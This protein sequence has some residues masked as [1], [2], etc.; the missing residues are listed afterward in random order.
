VWCV[1]QAFVLLSPES[2]KS[3]IVEMIFADNLSFLAM[4]RHA[5]FVVQ[6]A[7]GACTNRRLVSILCLLLSPPG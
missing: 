1:V 6:A 3:Q 5:N 7:L 2:L 4:H